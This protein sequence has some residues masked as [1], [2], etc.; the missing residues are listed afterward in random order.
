MERDPCVCW[1]Q[2]KQVFEHGQRRVAGLNP[3]SEMVKIPRS[4]DVGITA[5]LPHKR[6][7]ELGRAV[8][9]IQTATVY[10]WAIIIARVFGRVASQTPSQ[11]RAYC[12]TEPP[13]LVFPSWPVRLPSSA[14]RLSDAGTLIRCSRAGAIP[15]AEPTTPTLKD[16]E[17]MIKDFKNATVTGSAH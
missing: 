15:A 14:I 8:V 10:F 12:L 11:A 9:D 7:S 17:Q 5:G 1:G 4:G 2:C 13:P 6:T 16:H 3:M